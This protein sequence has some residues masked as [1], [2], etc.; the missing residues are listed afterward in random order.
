MALLPRSPIIFLAYLYQVYGHH[1]TEADQQELLRHAL[2][3]VPSTLIAPPGPPTPVPPSS[4]VVS[5]APAPYVHSPE[6]RRTF[7]EDPDGTDT[8]L[9]ILACSDP[10]MWYAT[11][12][13]Q[14]VVQIYRPIG[15]D[16]VST[17]YWSREPAGHVNIIHP[18]DAEVLIGNWAV[19]TP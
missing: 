15:F 8:A 5:P 17:N 3:G 9:R 6:A 11:L 2:P 16:K 1:F 14:V 4:P 10:S 19:G 12:V 7:I 18:C 13:G